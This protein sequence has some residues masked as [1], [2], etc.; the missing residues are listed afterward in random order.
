M[1]KFNNIGLAR[2]LTSCY[3]FQGFTEQEV[4][5]RIAQKINIIIE[6][7]NYLDKK[8]ENEKENNKAKFDYLL[9]QGLTEQ[10]AKVILEKIKDGSLGELINDTLLKDIN[11]EIE[12]INEQLVTIV[13][14]KTEWKNAVSYGVKNNNTDTT[15][16]LKE[17]FATSNNCTVYFGKGY[18]NFNEP[19]ELPENIEVICD[20]NA[21]FNFNK[22]TILP[23]E[24]G[25]GTLPMFYR[26]SNVDDEGYVL[27]ENGS[28]KWIGGIINGNGSYHLDSSQ[29]NYWDSS[30]K[31]GNTAWSHDYQR[32]FLL[33]GYESVEIN[34]VKIND[35]FGHAIG[36]YGNKYFSV[37]NVEIMQ[38]IDSITHPNGHSRRDGISG[39]S[40]NIKITNCK[41][42]SDDDSIA[43]VNRLDWGFGKSKIES[44]IIDNIKLLENNK[45][46]PI[47]A[48]AI[49]GDNNNTSV[50]DKVEMNNIQGTVSTSVYKLQESYIKNFSF[51]NI[52]LTVIGD[53][54]TDN[55]LLKT[56]CN[57][58]LLILENVNIISE[59][60]TSYNFIC[61]G[62]RG[63]PN[64]T[65]T[66]KHISFNNVSYQMNNTIAYSD[67]VYC[68][69][70]M[71]LFSN[72]KVYVI[73]GNVKVVQNNSFDKSYVIYNGMQGDIN[74][75]NIYTI[76]EL[77]SFSN[78]IDN[79]INNITNGCKIILKSSSI[80]FND[81][82]ELLADFSFNTN[83]LTEGYNIFR[84]SSH[85][86]IQFHIT[87]VNV[88]TKGSLIR[89]AK[90]NTNYNIN[91]IIGYA[92]CDKPSENG[93][94]NGWGGK[95]NSI[96]I[97]DTNKYI[98]IRTDEDNIKY[99]LIRL[100]IPIFQ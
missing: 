4:W 67:D 83:Y 29:E 93:G 63:I 3:D 75:E 40:R 36:H 23:T 97:L 59:I 38:G 89:I 73:K 45:H 70:F 41:I 94:N 85:L 10:V 92:I 62:L 14:N 87:N 33:C 42:F 88:F 1:E 71:Y 8:I 28:F 100:E 35:I 24:A 81:S 39:G 22:D 49:Y 12:S 19:I 82:I 7:F 56:G 69:S 77:E 76:I 52:D 16:K 44:V 90:L 43:L 15:T 47:Q 61:I 46:Y 6:H 65:S 64:A 55:A 98:Y 30:D 20:D 25:S 58:D 18:Y 79:K 99:C 66:V 50:I 95:F 34:N 54:S 21:I 27:I 72:C 80:I 53:F 86:I 91:K 37:N 78:T 68:S 13:L 31:D 48:I 2:E 26:K 74:N 96:C 51:K 11:N 17:F 84:T 57:I 5:S 32:A 9:G 60:D